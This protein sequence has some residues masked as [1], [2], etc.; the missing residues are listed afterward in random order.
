MTAGRPDPRIPAAFVG[1]PETRPPGPDPL[2]WC[3]YATVSL[4]T[5]VLGP[6]VL[7]AF[8]LI[9]LIAYG[10]AYIGGRRRSRCLLR[11]TRLVL[12]YAAATLALGV[13]ATVRGW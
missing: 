1:G 4:L 11:D 6:A 9:A 8:S 10:R 7:V 3:V 2:H 12:L 5:V 13:V